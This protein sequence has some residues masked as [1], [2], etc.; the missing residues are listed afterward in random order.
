M[1]ERKRKYSPCIIVHGG[2]WSIP[3]VFLD[4]YYAGIQKAVKAGFEALKNV[5]IEFYCS[6]YF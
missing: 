4:A 6:T 3:D 2:A 1:E 5:S